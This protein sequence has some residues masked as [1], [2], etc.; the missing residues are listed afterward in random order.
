MKKFIGFCFTVL[1]ML[2]LSTPVF[3][4]VYGTE[5][6]PIFTGKYTLQGWI[7][8]GAGSDGNLNDRNPNG[9][10]GKQTLFRKACKSAADAKYKSASKNYKARQAL[11][12]AF[13]MRDLPKEVGSEKSTPCY[14]AYVGLKKSEHPDLQ[15]GD[16]VDLDKKHLYVFW[17]S[18]VKRSGVYKKD[19]VTGTEPEDWGNTKSAYGGDR[20]HY[21]TFAYGILPYSSGLGLKLNKNDKDPKWYTTTYHQFQ[22]SNTKANVYIAGSQESSPRNSRSIGL[23]LRDDTDPGENAVVKDDECNHFWYVTP[24]GCNSEHD[25]V[26][27]GNYNNYAACVY[28]IRY[29]VFQKMRERDVNGEFDSTFAATPSGELKYRVYYVSGRPSIWKYDSKSKTGSWST[30]LYSS[31]AA[32]DNVFSKTLRQTTADD[33]NDQN[34]GNAIVIPEPRGAKLRIRIWDEYNQEVAKVYKNDATSSEAENAV[35]NMTSNHQIYWDYKQ[36]RKDEGNEGKTSNIYALQ[37]SLLYLL[38]EYGYVADGTG[39]TDPTAHIE[40]YPA[41]KT[42][43]VSKFKTKSVFFRT[44]DYNVVEGVADQYDVLVPTGIRVYAGTEAKSAKYFNGQDSYNTCPEARTFL[45]TIQVQSKQNDTGHRGWLNFDPRQ[46]MKNRE[47]ELCRKGTVLPW[48]RDTRTDKKNNDK[49]AYCVT[50]WLSDK[51]ISSSFADG[52]NDPDL[53]SIGKAIGT[54]TGEIDFKRVDWVNSRSGATTLCPQTWREADE[55]DP[56]VYIDVICERV[57][58][59]EDGPTWYGIDVPP[60]SAASMDSNDAWGFADYDVTVDPVYVHNETNDDNFEN[61]WSIAATAENYKKKTNI[62]YVFTGGDSLDPRYRPADTIGSTTQNT[63]ASHYDAETGRR[64]VLSHVNVYDKTGKSQSA[65][66]THSFPLSGRKNGYNTSAWRSAVT[67]FTVKLKD[68][69]R[70][71]TTDFFYVIKPPL[72]VLAY[73]ENGAGIYTLVDVSAMPAVTRFDGADSIC[74]DTKTLG[75]I[76]P[77][78]E[79]NKDKYDIRQAYPEQDPRDSRAYEGFYNPG[80][81]ITVGIAGNLTYKLST[82]SQTNYIWEEGHAEATGHNSGGGPPACK[83]SMDF[84]SCGVHGG[85]GNK[86]HYALICTKPEH[87]HSAG[88]FPE[89][90]PHCTMEAHVHSL[91]E[92]FLD[93][94]HTHTVGSVTAQH[95]YGASFGGSY[96]MPMDR[97]SI[98][99]KGVYLASGKIASYDGLQSYIFPSLHDADTRRSIGSQVFTSNLPA[100]SGNRK[101]ITTGHGI[102]FTYHTYD[103][104]RLTGSTDAAAGQAELDIRMMN[105]NPYN[106]QYYDSDGGHP[107]DMIPKPISTANVEGKQSY[108][109]IERN[110]EEYLLIWP[111][112]DYQARNCWFICRDWE[113]VVPNSEVLADYNVSFSMGDTSTYLVL[114]YGGKN[115]PIPDSSPIRSTFG[116]TVIDLFHDATTN[117]YTVVDS[118]RF[119][120][121]EFDRTDC[122]L[123]TKY[124]SGSYDVY[125]PLHDE[126]AVDIGYTFMD[127]NYGG[128]DIPKVYY[129]KPIATWSKPTN[130]ELNHGGL[131]QSLVIYIVWEKPKE[132]QSVVDVIFYSKDNNKANYE[133][134]TKYQ[135]LATPGSYISPSCLSQGIADDSG[136]SYSSRLENMSIGYAESKDQMYYYDYDSDGDGDYD[137]FFSTECLGVIAPGYFDSSKQPGG[138]SKSYNGFSVPSSW[139]SS[140]DKQYKVGAKGTVIYVLLENKDVFSYVYPPG[141]PSR[142]EIKIS[143]T[144]K[145]E[146]TYIPPEEIDWQPANRKTSDQADISNFSVSLDSEGQQVLIRTDEKNSTAYAGQYDSQV[147]I[148]TSEYLK[149]VANVLKYETQLAI[150]KH[151]VTW[152]YNYVNTESRPLSGGPVTRSTT[153]YTVKQADTYI[154][155]D[156]T[157]FNDTLN[158][159]VGYTKME[160]NPDNAPWVN[161]SLGFH[162]IRGASV[163][164]PSYKVFDVKGALDEYVAGGYVLNPDDMTAMLESYVDNDQSSTNDLLVFCDGEGNYETLSIDNILANGKNDGIRQAS[165]AGSIEGSDVSGATTANGDEKDPLFTR[166]QLILADRANGKHPS[167]YTTGLVELWSKS[168]EDYGISELVDVSKGNAGAIIHWTNFANDWPKYETDASGKRVRTGETRNLGFSTGSLLKG[169]YDYHMGIKADDVMIHTPVFSNHYIIMDETKVQTIQSSAPTDL[170]MDVPFIV[171]TDCIG[172]NRS[173]PGYGVQDYSRYLYKDAVEGSVQNAV[174]VKFPFPV[175]QKT[176]A[177]YRDDGVTPVTVN[178]YYYADTWIPIK[179]G[180]TEFYM[181]YWIDEVAFT[182][183]QYR[184]IAE[185][186][187][188]LD[189]YEIRDNKTWLLSNNFTILDNLR[190]TEPKQ[191]LN[192]DGILQDKDSFN[193]NLYDSTSVLTDR[194]SVG[195]RLYQVEPVRNCFQQNYVATSTDDVS[196]SGRVYGFKI[197]DISDYPS[198]KQYFR[199]ADGTI[200]KNVFTSGITNR[201]G[202]ANGH[203]STSV[204]PTLNGSNPNYVNTGILNPGY[205]IKYTFETVGNMYSSDDYVEII[206]HFHWLNSA[207]VD[208]GEVSVYYANTVANGQ[209]QRLIKVGSEQD[210]KN[211][212]VLALGDLEYAPSDN[213]GVISSDH[214]VYDGS[215]PNDQHMAAKYLGM[216]LADFLQ[217]KNEVWSMSYTKLDQYLRTY[218]GVAH[219]TTLSAA[220]DHQIDYFQG[221]R[222]SVASAASS[223]YDQ[224]DIYRGIQEWYGEYYLPSVIY[225][226]KESDSIVRQ[227]CSTDLTGLEPCWL[228]DGYLAITFE[229]NTINQNVKYLSYNNT[230]YNVNSGNKLDA[231]GEEVV[232]YPEANADGSVSDEQW[233]WQ[234]L[235]DSGGFDVDPGKCNMWTWESYLTSRKDSYGKTFNL[236]KGDVIL[237]EIKYKPGINHSAGNDYQG[238]GTH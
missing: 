161:E 57:E 162:V 196:V 201:D 8:E 87:S 56:I 151:D 22:Q 72:V 149:T 70:K 154:P 79:P 110:H 142:P 64:W 49:Q 206:P 138:E 180:N 179:V 98:N 200:A 211:V 37:M 83:F 146:I 73:Y 67:T 204:I 59:Y 109:P 32:I 160:L 140:A 141:G 122:T 135:Y 43:Q 193:V 103:R 129:G 104:G 207:G 99:S 217:H 132:A 168:N 156:V 93:N 232:P 3:A 191:E 77:V 7:H 53:K 209:F 194:N 226:T 88:C 36:T 106:V 1:A 100:P 177:Y 11:L 182:T 86:S 174:Q 230:I 30:D 47:G 213:Y 60:T 210:T 216:T 155:L 80:D 181:P 192:A 224:D 172:E 62:P 96:G 186:A 176:I 188:V 48:K 199:N 184:S 74:D 198:W 144:M 127:T 205:A 126:G 28:Y 178:R 237:Y 114:M 202:A 238:A 6:N 10:D 95:I 145:E 165:P 16:D 101:T 173:D 54:T 128:F 52:V 34:I 9:T 69:T 227:M 78:V 108:D 130:L 111:G 218:D 27:S 234:N 20:T 61:V 55:E 90:G 75:T 125:A 185:N 235:S 214:L 157:V 14:Y 208:Q 197:V 113:T 159:N 112:S 183:V 38:K 29:W 133:F 190:I 169:D 107:H 102:T 163:S 23:L 131:T 164:A 68:L 119:S 203:S 40:Y 121:W 31:K 82:V 25:Q 105:S 189:N 46:T 150:E 15:V 65:L 223:G 167:G 222:A 41:T 17:V 44:T 175:I 228:S 139:K 58:H 221:L 195:Y 115:P 229:I 66:R 84:C 170:V 13:P 76:Q 212:K 124:S 81:G 152:T 85:C 42:Q 63:I 148:P 118:P 94:Q 225:V 89:E 71:W 91:H 187:Q 120:Q 97:V 143:V 134:F 2:M 166:N 24:I 33:Y 19:S 26:G 233:I 215:T 116:Y 21:T 5:S 18:S 50:T 219:G 137:H 147:N 153:Y 123:G 92:C 136:S 4:D 236:T 39:N 231:N 35:I 51:I 45:N 117:T 12:D 158:G 220:Y 171:H